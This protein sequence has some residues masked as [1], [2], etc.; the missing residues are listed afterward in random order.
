MTV[1]INVYLLKSEIS[2]SWVLGLSLAKIYSAGSMT[3]LLIVWLINT[4]GMWLY[5]NIRTLNITH[6]YKK[7]PN[8]GRIKNIRNRMQPKFITKVHSNHHFVG[9]K[10]TPV[11][12]DKFSWRAVGIDRQSYRSKLPV[13]SPKWL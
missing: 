3:R 6:S 8:T 9:S 10:L 2:A 12:S 1:S 4:K 13:F 7:E 11:I 5:S